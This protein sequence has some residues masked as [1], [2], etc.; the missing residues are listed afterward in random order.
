MVAKAVD[1]SGS[2]TTCRVYNR[3]TYKKD[4]KKNNKKYNDF[5]R[6]LQVPVVE[7]NIFCQ[8][9]MVVTVRIATKAFILLMVLYVYTLE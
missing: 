6:L 8:L 9:Q 5:E 2:D 4:N 3:L 1:S 7:R